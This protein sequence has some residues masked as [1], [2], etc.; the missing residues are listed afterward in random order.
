MSKKRKNVKD[1]PGYK[2]WIGVRDR[3]YNEHGKDYKR[4]GARN[5]Q[6][7]LTYEDFRD[8]YFRS[9][10]CEC[11]GVSFEKFQRTIDRIDNDGHIRSKYE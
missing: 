8:L 7:L 1:L 2:V 5:I 10:Q 9:D 4:Y 6:C 3:C 11:C